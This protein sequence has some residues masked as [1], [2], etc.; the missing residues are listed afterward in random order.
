MSLVI[1]AKW[2][3]DDILLTGSPLSANRGAGAEGGKGLPFS[4]TSIIAATEVG[5]DLFPL[6]VV[7]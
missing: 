3:S 1:I 4:I 6:T 2:R 7:M 5:D